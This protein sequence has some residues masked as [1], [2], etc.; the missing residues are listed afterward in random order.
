MKKLIVSSDSKPA[1]VS[2]SDSKPEPSSVQ[3]LRKFPPASLP[4]R[5]LER[6]MLVIVGWQW[7]RQ[8]L[9]IRDKNIL[10]KIYNNNKNLC[11]TCVQKREI[12]T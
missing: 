10:L 3:T 11:Y 1:Q 9:I 12:V 6:V 5:E 8:M 7:W 4:W 2:D